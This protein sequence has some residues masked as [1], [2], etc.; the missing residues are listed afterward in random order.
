MV[1]VRVLFLMFFVCCLTGLF[2]SVIYGIGS[3]LNIGY[4]E[5]YQLELVKLVIKNFFNWIF[6]LILSY[7]ALN[8]SFNVKH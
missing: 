5:F 1:I 7:L 3:F 8:K 6:G 4:P 2:A